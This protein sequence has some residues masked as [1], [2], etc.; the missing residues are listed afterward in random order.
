MAGQRGR[1][2]RRTSGSLQLI[3]SINVGLGTSILIIKAA[4][5]FLVISVSKD[6]VTLLTEVENIELAE[7]SGQVFDPG[8]VPFGKILAKFIKPKDSNS[9]GDEN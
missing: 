3:D 9:S 7:E 4:D 6:R 2:F 5:K 8:Q 1:Q